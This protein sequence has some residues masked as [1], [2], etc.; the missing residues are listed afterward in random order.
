MIRSAASFKLDDAFHRAAEGNEQWN[1]WV[2]QRDEVLS[3]RPRSLVFSFDQKSEV[4]YEEGPEL[5]TKRVYF[6]AELDWGITDLKGATLKALDGDFVINGQPLSRFL[7]EIEISPENE[8]WV[9]DDDEVA[10]WIGVTQ[11]MPLFTLF[12][13][14]ELKS[15]IYA[16][17]GGPVLESIAQT[18][19]WMV[20]RMVMAT[21]SH[22]HR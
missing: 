14:P 16:Y 12:H 6:M 9:H 8:L 18:R 4:Q 3:H 22:S 1:S 15:R 13:N 5:E 10:D 2:E 21:P 20:E 19:P 7:H 11:R 17:E